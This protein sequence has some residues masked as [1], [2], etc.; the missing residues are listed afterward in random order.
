MMDD[1][2]LEHY[3]VLGMRWGIRKANKYER[4]ARKA[5]ARN[6]AA[7]SQKYMAKS[8]KLRKKHTTRAGGEKAV[9]Y[10]RSQSLGKTLVKSGIFGTHGALRYNELRSKDVSRGRAAVAGLIYN[11]SNAVTTSAVGFVEP[12]LRQTKLYKQ[13]TKTSRGVN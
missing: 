8:K 12:R 9:K 5:N 13:L 4:K 11:A 1:N 2:Y 3:G 7:L 10:T 6:D